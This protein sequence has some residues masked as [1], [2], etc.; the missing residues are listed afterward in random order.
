MN[1]W[2]RTAAKTTKFVSALTAEVEMVFDHNK[3]EILENTP[4][5]LYPG[6]TNAQSLLGKLF[7]IFKKCLFLG[8]HMRP[9]CRGDVT[10]AF[11]CPEVIVN[12]TG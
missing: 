10:D 9:A 7:R 12:D 3:A 6:G 4:K 1:I 8:I 5:H 2:R 11:W